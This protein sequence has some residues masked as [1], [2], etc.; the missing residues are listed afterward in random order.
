MPLVMEKASIGKMVDYYEELDKRGLIFSEYTASNG[1]D[2]VFLVCPFHPDNDPSLAVSLVGGQFKCFGCQ[3][4]GNFYQLIAEIDGV[5]VSQARQMLKEDETVERA[6]QGID[7]DLKSLQEEKTRYYNKQALHN[8]FKSFRHTKAEEYLWTRRVRGSTMKRFDVRY[9]GMDG[10]WRHRVILPIYTDKGKL[11]AWTGRS[12]NQS[13]PKTK[14]NRSARSTLYGLYELIQNK[15]KWMVSV[16]KA[17]MLFV[18][19]GEIDAMYLQQFGYHAVAAMGTAGLSKQQL[20]LVIKY[21][22][23]VALSYDNDFAGELATYGNKKREGDYNKLKKL[24][25]VTVVKLPKKKDPNDLTINAVQKLFNR[26][27]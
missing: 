20:A 22:N 3:E 21:A 2:N 25:P 6:L 23:R 8:R 19:E 24:L 17:P 15:P 18:V 10:R 16:F 9:G 27:N 11:L 1:E 13:K 4:D 7:R 14:K 5:S 12:V 26:Y